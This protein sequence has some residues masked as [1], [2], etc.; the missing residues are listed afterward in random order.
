MR[1]FGS[2]KAKDSFDKATTASKSM[3][4]DLNAIRLV[5]VHSHSYTMFMMDLHNLIMLN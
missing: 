5:G 2:D 4:V 3:G 1:I